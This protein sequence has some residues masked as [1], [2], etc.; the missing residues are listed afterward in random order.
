MIGESGWSAWFS[1]KGMI[2]MIGEWVDD[3]QFYMIGEWM[4]FMIGEQK[5]YVIGE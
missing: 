4:I 2:Y 5:I 3:L 1:S